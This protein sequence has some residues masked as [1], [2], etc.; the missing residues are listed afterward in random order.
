MVASGLFGGNDDSPPLDTGIVQPRA[1][2]KIPE[3]EAASVVDD[4]RSAAARARRQ[5]LAG[6]RGVTLPPQTDTP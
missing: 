2:S 3:G 1:L 4:L 6:R 5:R